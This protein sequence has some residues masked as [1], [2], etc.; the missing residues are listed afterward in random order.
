MAPCHSKWAPMYYDMSVRH[1]A[2]A[3]TWVHVI[4]HGTP[5]FIVCSLALS[6]FC[7]LYLFVS[8]V[9]LRGY[10]VDYMYD[11]MSS[12]MGSCHSTIMGPCMMTCHST[13]GPCHSTWAPCTCQMTMYCD[14][15]QST[16]AEVLVHGAEV[17]VH[18]HMDSD[19]PRRFAYTY[20]LIP[21]G[22]SGLSHTVTDP[23]H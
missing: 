23:Q 14:G 20:S 22:R 15:S 7:L 13:W 10:I 5:C 12:Y 16:C 18:G 2:C 6:D 19:L 9:K 11:D 21:Y 3:V 1:V 4:V 17:M 8:F